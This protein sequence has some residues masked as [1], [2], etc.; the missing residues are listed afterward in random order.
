[1]GS[2]LSFALFT[3]H[4]GRR[5]VLATRRSKEPSEFVHFHFSSRSHTRSSLTS[6][7]LRWLLLGVV[8]SHF[9]RDLLQMELRRRSPLTA[10]A[11]AAVV[12]SC[13][14]AL[15][16]VNAQ[17]MQPQFVRPCP[18]L[19]FSQD[20]MATGE[21][22]RF[23]FQ[24]TSQPMPDFVDIHYGSG[25]GTANDMNVKMMR[26]G[27]GFEH[28]DPSLRSSAG[29]RYYFTYAANGQQCDSEP[30][31]ASA[32][33]SSNSALMGFA[34]QPQPLMQQQPPPPP[35]Q[36]AFVPS[37]Q[38][39][40][41]QAVQSGGAYGSI[42]ANAQPLFAMPNVAPA[43][44]GG[45]GGG[46]TVCP[47]VMSTL[48]VTPIGAQGVRFVFQSTDGTPLTR[49]DLHF[50]LSGQP[51]NAFNTRMRSI[52]PSQWDYL[53]A[54]LRAEQRKDIVLLMNHFRSLMVLLLVLL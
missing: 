17:Q 48:T 32:G 30:F 6:S 19:T 38:S 2:T 23:R 4:V 51:T 9:P 47:A 5:R 52:T 25:S 46:R 33:G 15:Q 43:I 49:V 26:N 12:V 41:P 3:V 8:R 13:A 40:I 20:A 29:L 42:N 27:Q 11:F 28:F 50:G 39:F 44:A 14:V 31:G 54:E 18:L 35:Q 45:S 36:F 22:V 1:M 53:A 34:A 10:A 21:G 37:Q 16:M 24:P 7:P